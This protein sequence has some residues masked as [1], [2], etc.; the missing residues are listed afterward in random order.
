MSN[1]GGLC[2]TRTNNGCHAAVLYSKST[3]GGATWSS[4]ALAF[5]AS[6]ASNQLAIGYPVNQ[7][8]G[9]TL[10][11]PTPR[12]VDTL[13]PAVA[14]TPSGRVYISAYAA[15]VI[16]PGRRAPADPRHRSAESPATCWAIT[17][18]TPAWTMWFA[19]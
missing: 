16:S 19:I 2:P 8:D 6:D 4:P 14:A 5:P 9:S 15:D 13:F 3:D 11:V 7:P 18:T 12:R 1:T 10:E 17:S